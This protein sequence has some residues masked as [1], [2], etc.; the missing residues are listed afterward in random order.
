VD[1]FVGAAGTLVITAV[2]GGFLAIPGIRLRRR[3]ERLRDWAN[4]NGWTITP[5][6]L[7]IWYQDG[8]FEYP[9]RVAIALTGTVRGHQVTVT[10]YMYQ[11]GRLGKGITSW[12]RFVVVSIWLR[13]EYP[14][15][16][17]HARGFASSLGRMLTGEQELP[18][19]E[20]A[21]GRVDFDRRFRLT[22]LDP[23]TARRVV[24][25][26]LV[27]AHLAGEVPSWRA[28]GTELTAHAHGRITSPDRIGTLTAPLLRVA[29]LLDR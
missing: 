8:P 5:R 28:S 23:D 29:D 13:R 3:W 24:G 1:F 19:R 18:L 26:P 12:Y 10:E 2:I 9:R 15:T 6:P 16:E 22:S 25:A 11:N 21:T 7:G 4:R 27:A 17:V 14:L 20:V